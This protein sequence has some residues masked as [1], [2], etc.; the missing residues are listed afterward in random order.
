MQ[1]RFTIGL[2]YYFVSRFLYLKFN[3]C[4]I[5]VIYILICNI[6]YYVLCNIKKWKNIF[7]KTRFM[8]SIICRDTWSHFSFSLLLRRN[9]ITSYL[10]RFKL[11]GPLR[12]SPEGSLN[13]EV[14]L[15]TELKNKVKSSINHDSIYKIETFF[16]IYFV[17]NRS[18]DKSRERY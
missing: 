7:L 10:L 8:K 12:V 16:F 9:I 18:Q 13:N 1:T 5:T 14:F 6:S 11:F 2:G 15:W 4:N 3:A 17:T